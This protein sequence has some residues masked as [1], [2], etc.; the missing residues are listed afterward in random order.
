MDRSV[1]AI[2]ST[3]LAVVFP[4]QGSR[5]VGMGRLLVAEYPAAKIRLAALSEEVDADLVGLLC[6][7][8][9]RR[10]PLSE[11]LALMSFG[12]GAWEWLTEVRGLRAQMLAG[13]SF[14]EIVALACAGTLSTEDA[15]RLARERGRCLAE[16]CERRP[17]VMAAFVG[18]SMVRMQATIAAWVAAAGFIESLW[19]VNFNSPGQLVVAGEA[20]AL[21]ALCAAMR[22]DGLTAI[23]LATAGAFHT[24]FMSEAALR[25]ADFLRT[26]DFRAPR[27]PVFSSMCGRLLTQ[28]EALAT[29]LAFHVIKPVRWLEAMQGLRR[30]QIGRVVEVAGGRGVLSPLI[31]SCEDWRVET[32]TLD[33]LLGAKAWEKRDVEG[34]TTV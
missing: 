5:R 29:H 25:F 3:R 26:L 13:H 32:T 22:A 8:E 21:Q 7:D 6:G 23:P 10:D 4:G 1:G 33:A 28:P 30:A 12:L 20:S 18:A 9:P 19:I 31:A 14:G 27:I 17:G 2:S 24:P 34:V 11:H 16:A 15:L